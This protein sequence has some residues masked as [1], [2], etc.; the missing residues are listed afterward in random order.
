MKTGEAK[1]KHAFVQF[2]VMEYVDG[3]DLLDYAVSR[4]GL[5]MLS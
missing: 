4:G 2:L 5:G 1:L 3:G